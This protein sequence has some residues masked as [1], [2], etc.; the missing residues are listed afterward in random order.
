MMLQ[1]VLWWLFVFV[2]ICCWSG[3]ET[4]AWRIRPHGF[5]TVRIPAS[6]QASKAEQTVLEEDYCLLVSV[7]RTTHTDRTHYA[8]NHHNILATTGPITS[9]IT[10]ESFSLSCQDSLAELSE[11]ARTAGIK[12]AGNLTQRM[13]LPHTHSYIGAGKVRD[14]AMMIEN[15][16]H[17]ISTVIVDDDLSV[18]QQRFLEETLTSYLRDPNF[19]HS[20][21]HTNEL[22]ENELQSQ[23]LSP[24]PEDDLQAADE[25]TSQSPANGEEQGQDEEEEDPAFTAIFDRM[26]SDIDKWD[27]RKRLFNYSQTDS[28]LSQSHTHLRS[29]ALPVIRVLDRT[30][31]ILS[32]FAQHARSREGQL[33]VQLAAM[34]YALAK[35]GTSAGRE[36][37]AS[38]VRLN[39]DQSST[40][41]TTPSTTT[42]TTT[43][44]PTKSFDRSGF[45]SAG[46]TAIEQRRR[47][48][49]DKMHAIQQEIDN[50]ARQREQLREQRDNKLALPVVALIGYTNSGKV[51]DD[52][53][54]LH[55][56][57]YEFVCC[58]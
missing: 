17:V 31:L 11:L 42:Q 32:I 51:I 25:L 26:L 57:V 22:S 35:H 10:G 4:Y 40:I 24:E 48:I 1:Q 14:L 45:R 29:T 15:S 16:P 56:Y 19:K 34:K 41:S 39:A 21:N 8:Q 18:R 36:I 52:V 3:S 58:Q 33:Q 37:V 23:S 47:D 49:R 5:H 2:S 27:H 38:T 30:A 43:A 50:L 55:C 20:N 53:V 12:V 9:D 46:E 28:D 44:N 7:D 6:L 54:L 13:P